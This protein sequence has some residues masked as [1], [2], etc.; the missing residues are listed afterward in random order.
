MVTADYTNCTKSLEEYIRRTIESLTGV[1]QG[2]AFT[3]TARAI[4]NTPLGNFEAYPGRYAERAKLLGLLPEPGYAQGS[5]KITSD[6]STAGESTYDGEQAF[7][8]AI[9]DAKT[10]ILG[11][12]IYITNSGPYIRL[13]EGGFS[14]QAPKGMIQPTL[15][16]VA[17]IYSI[18]LKDYYKEV[19]N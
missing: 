3:M 6:G 16:E 10:Y 13:L 7:Q 11:E 5:W 12:D 2:F 4:K 14:K 19:T 8:N 1:V 15:A 9:R 18:S 17:D